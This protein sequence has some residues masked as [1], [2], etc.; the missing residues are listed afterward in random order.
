MVAR[1]P[2]IESGTVKSLPPQG[3]N[4]VQSHATDNVLEEGPLAFKFSA[5]LRDL[6]NTA[7][8]SSPSNFSAPTKQKHFHRFSENS[9]N[10]SC[11]LHGASFFMNASTVRRLLNAGHDVNGLG[12]SGLTPLHLAFFNP[13]LAV[14]QYLIRRGA[15]VDALVLDTGRN[16]LNFSVLMGSPDVGKILLD[17]G[18]NVDVKA[19]GC[20][21]T[22][23]INAS[24]LGCVD[25]VTLLLEYGA[26][27]SLKDSRG[28]TAL[29][30]A[31]ENNNKEITK[32]L[33]Q[34]SEKTQIEEPPISPLRSP[35]SSNAVRTFSVSLMNKISR[36]FDRINL[37]D[38]GNSNAAADRIGYP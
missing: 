8:V 11:D 13:D 12:E 20:G 31:E 18:A 5:G 35:F 6:V 1:R 37:T 33:L 23:L 26:D 16:M 25:F 38:S 34:H 14:M 15:V 2:G 19:V 17:G 28:R 29:S 36:S 21:E 4:A 22:A 9:K 32:F 7:S 24:E 10:V 30:V 27:A 3:V